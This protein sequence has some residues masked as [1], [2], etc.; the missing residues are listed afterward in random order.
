[1]SL[2][3]ARPAPVLLKRR[4]SYELWRTVS[5]GGFTEGSTLYV[6]RFLTGTAKGTSGNDYVR[7][8]LE[9]WIKRMG[10]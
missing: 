1:M 9:A 10:Y 3:A 4:K 7:K 5:E 6:V 2:P 8:D